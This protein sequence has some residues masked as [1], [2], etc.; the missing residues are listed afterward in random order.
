MFRAFR[1]GRRSASPSPADSVEHCCLDCMQFPGNDHFRRINVRHSCPEPQDCSRWILWVIAGLLIVVGLI[2]LM[3]G[4]ADSAFG[5]EG[6]PVVESPGPP[7]LLPGTVDQDLEPETV[8][9]PTARCFTLFAA[10]YCSGPRLVADCVWRS[11]SPD[12][13]SSRW[14]AD[15]RPFEV[16]GWVEGDTVKGHPVTD[17]LLFAVWLEPEFDPA[18]HAVLIGVAMCESGGLQFIRST[19]SSAYGWWQHLLRFVLGATGRLVAAGFPPDIDVMEPAV[20]TRI[21]GRLWAFGSGW[22]HWIESFHCWKKY[23]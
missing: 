5:V 15:S 4:L 23:Q 13:C 6:E 14:F 19:I 11:I 21:T 12:F 3:V 17:D 10:D 7:S 8:Y 9:R 18:D 1:R 20:Q 16:G 2:G 22:R